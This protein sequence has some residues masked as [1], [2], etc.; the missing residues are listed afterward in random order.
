MGEREN[1][2]ER[3]LLESTEGST[4]AR[5][6]EWNYSNISLQLCDFSVRTLSCLA[7]SIEQGLG[8][9]LADMVADHTS[10]R[11]LGLLAREWLKS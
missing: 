1:W 11:K 8:F 2:L 10:A 9:C 3:G 5:N 4:E 6:Y 7:A